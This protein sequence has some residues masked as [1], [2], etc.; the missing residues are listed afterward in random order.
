MQSGPVSSYLNFYHMAHILMIGMGAAAGR[1]FAQK[2]DSYL[3]QMNL[4]VEYSLFSI[5]S[6]VVGWCLYVAL[7]LT[8]R[9]LKKNLQ[10]EA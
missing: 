10:Q 5:V 4:E 1:L 9:T 3:A 2:V 8:I 7:F 6:D